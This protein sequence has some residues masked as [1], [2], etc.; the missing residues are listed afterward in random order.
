VKRTARVQEKLTCPVSKLCTAAVPMV[1][2]PLS[3]LTRQTVLR[4]LPLPQRLIAA[5]Q[6]SAAAPTILPQHKELMALAANRSTCP[7]PT[8]Q[9]RCTAAALMAF[10]QHSEKSSRDVPSTPTV[11]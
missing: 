1:S 4:T 11:L 8:V 9:L 2:L 6:H 5:E 10:T 3:L 7:L